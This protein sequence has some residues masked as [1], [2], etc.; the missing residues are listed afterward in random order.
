MITFSLRFSL[1]RIVLFDSC[2]RFLEIYVR[3][4]FYFLMVLCI[5]IV[6][7][8]IPKYI[9]RLDLPNTG[10]TSIFDGRVAFLTFKYE[11]KT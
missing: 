2:V 4:Y 9:N 11:R 7:R 8:G 6:L 3:S 10:S 1:K 5:E